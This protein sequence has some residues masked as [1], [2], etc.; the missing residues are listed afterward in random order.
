MFLAWWDMDIKESR[1]TPNTLMVLQVGRRLPS[2]M[3]DRGLDTSAVH[4]VKSE[5]IN[6]E[7]ERHSLRS[8]N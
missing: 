2:T 3:M 6:L 5:L 8:F 4:V 1:V 7:G